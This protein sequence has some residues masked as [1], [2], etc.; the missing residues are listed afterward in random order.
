MMPEPLQ[1][2]PYADVNEALRELRVQA[3]TILGP[4]FVGMYLSGSL[5]LGDFDPHSSDIDLVIVTDA[6]LSD[7]LFAALQEM[8]ARFAAGGS[9]W[10]AKLEAVYI[11]EQALRRDAPTGAVYPVLEKCRALVMDHLESGWSVQCYTLR[12]HGLAVAGPEPR[13]LVDPVDPNGMRRAGSAIAGMWLEQARVDPS[14]LAWL[15]RRENQ[16]FVVLTLCRLL[17]TLETGAVASK[18]GAAR[19]AQPAVGP[20][21]AGLIE[22]ALAG[23]HDR[24]E[25]PESDADETVALIQ[26]TVDR[27]RRWEASSP[28]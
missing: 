23:Q 20:R 3:H 19:W 27:F 28:T 25:I 18:P 16:A 24:T 12:E 4:H 5:A 1:P 6:P 13:T 26:H 17:Y 7:D 11:P 21:W 10:A 15:R 14:W 22:R 8:H 9:P 2:T